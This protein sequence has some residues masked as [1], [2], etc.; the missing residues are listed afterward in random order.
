MYV[1]Y[2]WV[3]VSLLVRSIVIPCVPFP[4][5][6]RGYYVCP[7]YMGIWVRVSLLVRRISLKIKIVP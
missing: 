6:G 3:R 2:I 1:P 4:L 5:L 7:I